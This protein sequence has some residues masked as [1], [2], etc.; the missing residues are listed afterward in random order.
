MSYRHFW[1]LVK[2]ENNLVKAS[3]PAFISL[4]LKYETLYLTNT[5]ATS[6]S[7]VENMTNFSSDLAV[8]N[9]G[10]WLLYVLIAWTQWLLLLP[11]TLIVSADMP[12]YP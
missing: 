10:Q 7:T 12:R 1:G 3:L 5:T 9:L 4:Y 8:T 2:T 6:P 11:G